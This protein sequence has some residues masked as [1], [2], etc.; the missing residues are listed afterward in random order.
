[1]NDATRLTVER[2][3]SHLAVL[4]ED[5]RR[6]LRG[7][8]HFDVQDV[9]QL[10]EPIGEM[11]LIVAQWAEVRRLQP[12]IAGPLDLYK[13]QLGELQTTLRRIRIMLLARQASLQASQFHNTAVSRWV[14]ALRQTR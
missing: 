2:V 6:A 14:C 13:S 3:N 1:M 9:R 8:R 11:T 12:E 10:R 5:A 7:E 4:L